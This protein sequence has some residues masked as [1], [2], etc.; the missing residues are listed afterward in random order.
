MIMVLLKVL[1]EKEQTSIWWQQPVV[2]VLPF[3]AFGGT[4]LFPP[5]R[6]IQPEVGRLNEMN[7]YKN[8]TS[9]I[10][11]LQITKSDLRKRLVSM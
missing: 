3:Y 2:N 8:M 9:I 11:I 7:V 6:C 5:K 10:K 1:R 4:E